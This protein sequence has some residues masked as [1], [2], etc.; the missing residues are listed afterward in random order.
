MDGYLA[1]LY[2][3]DRLSEQFHTMSEAMEIWEYDP[4]SQYSGANSKLLADLSSAFSQFSSSIS[5]VRHHVEFIHSIQNSLQSAKRY[6]QA[7]S[8]DTA[9]WNELARN[10]KR[11][12][13][14]DADAKIAAEES[15][16]PDMQKDAM[17]R[18]MSIQFGALADFSKE[19]MV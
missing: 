19:T 8:E 5:T 6:R 3:L 4:F 14:Q 18:W 9:G 12:E 10:M 13:I 15:R 2:P 11:I 16:F 7:L 1:A 17:K